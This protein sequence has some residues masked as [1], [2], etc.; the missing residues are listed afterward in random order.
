MNLVNRVTLAVV[1]VSLTSAVSLAIHAVQ[2]RAPVSLKVVPANMKV[3][4]EECEAPKQNLGTFR[5]E[6]V[7]LV[8]RHN[9]QLMETG[10]IDTEA[11]RELRSELDYAERC[12]SGFAL[13]DV[14]V[15]EDIAHSI[16]YLPR[17]RRP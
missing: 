8:E 6:V 2:H 14:D 17:G 3:V 11:S 15:S 4:A 10:R 7:Q 5:L 13:A 16:G 1:I 12:W 9:I